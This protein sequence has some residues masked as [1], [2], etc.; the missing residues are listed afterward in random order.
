MIHTAAWCLPVVKGGVRLPKGLPGWEAFRFASSAVWPDSTSG[1]DHWYGAV[2]GTVSAG[3]TLLFI[4]G[5]P[6]VVL[7]GPRSLQRVSAWA[8]AAG[9]IVNA[10]WYVLYVSDRSDLRVGYFLWWFSFT[11]LAIGLFGLAGEHEAGVPSSAVG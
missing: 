6:W 3:T 11:V 4:F 1:F 9:F 8:A 5:S 7:R 10:H 2:L